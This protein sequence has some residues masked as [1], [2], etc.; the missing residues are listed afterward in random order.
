MGNME[1]TAGRARN[2]SRLRLLLLLH[3]GQSGRQKADG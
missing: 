1:A 2:A 3:D